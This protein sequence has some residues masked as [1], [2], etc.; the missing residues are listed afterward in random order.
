MGKRAADLKRDRVLQ[1]RLDQE[2]WQL[3]EAAADADSRPISQ[4]ARVQLLRAAE[5]VLPVAAVL[6]LHL[7]PGP[8]WGFWQHNPHA[9]AGPCAVQPGGKPPP[10]M[11]FGGFPPPGGPA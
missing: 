9:P 4:W 11:C 6:L 7:P 10:P 2:E 3:I 1:V 8:A 5:A